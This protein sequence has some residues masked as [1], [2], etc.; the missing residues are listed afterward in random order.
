MELEKSA[1]QVLS[2]SKG[3]WGE[4]DE[5]REHRGEMNQTVYSHV[6]K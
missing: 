6:N 5:R 2:G 3:G 1:E 4:K